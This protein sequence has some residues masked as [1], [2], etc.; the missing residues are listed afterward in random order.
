MRLL[1]ESA[2]A[3]ADAVI[4]EVGA[5][6]GDGGVIVVAPDGSRP[7]F[8]FN[9]P[10]HVPRRGPTASGLREV[11]IFSGVIPARERESMGNQLN[12]SFLRLPK[13]MSPSRRARSAA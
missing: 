11:A 10:G 9:T 5:L 4:A 1:G 13:R 12:L 8:A 6:G 3:A 2:Q 7:V